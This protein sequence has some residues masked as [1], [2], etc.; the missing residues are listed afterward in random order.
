MALLGSVVHYVVDGVCV[1]GIV[2]EVD[3]DTVGLTVFAP[4]AL[5]FDQRVPHGAPGSPGFPGVCDGFAR[6]DATWHCPQM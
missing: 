6:E 4:A 2:T 1:P 3:G 5:V